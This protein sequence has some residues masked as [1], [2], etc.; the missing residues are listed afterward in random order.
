MSLV[1]TTATHDGIPDISEWSDDRKRAL[2]E[3]AGNWQTMSTLG[4]WA[5]RWTMFAAGALTA[6]WAAL[7]IFDWHWKH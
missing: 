4:K 3:M 1:E 7:Q 5:T 6:I 2:Y